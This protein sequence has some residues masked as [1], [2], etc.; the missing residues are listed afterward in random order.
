MTNKDI[1][2]FSFNRT[3]NKLH[4]ISETY[5]LQ[6]LKPTRLE[7]YLILWYLIFFYKKIYFLFLKLNLFIN[8]LKYLKF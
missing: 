6:I 2:L 5:Y 8:F 1:Y 3:Q 7:F 4:F